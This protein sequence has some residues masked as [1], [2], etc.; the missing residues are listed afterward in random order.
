MPELVTDPS[1]IDARWLTDALREAGVLPRGRVREVRWR[2]IGTGK[3]GDNVRYDLLYDGA[4]ESAP[5]SVVAKLPAADATARASAGAQGLYRREVC[6]YREIAS[7]APIR[8]PAVHLTAM[9]ANGVDFVILMEDLAPAEP[10]DQIAGCRPER[11][12]LV[13]REAAKLH[14]PMA[15]DPILGAEWVMQATPEGVALVQAMLQEMW[16]GFA[17]RFE[18]AITPEGARLGER[19]TKSFP[20]W[21]LGF[22]G[23]ETLVHGDYRLENMLFGTESG[24]PPIAVVDW[25]SVQR[26]CPLVDVAYFLGAGLSIEDRRAHER[27]LVETYRRSLARL[28]VEI[29]PA[30]CWS[31]Y[32]RS[33]LHG[34]L[35]TVLGC[36]LSGRDERGDRMF[37]VMIERHLQHSI[38]L[39]CEEFLV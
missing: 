4:P 14:G 11:A 15:G 31:L 29:T 32:R 1:A 37:A 39:G 6:F 27:E 25:Q 36:M 16:P 35:I 19:F 12:D 24:G 9:D 7:R 13:L 34:I 8:T 20:E 5:S 30:D 2:T 21:T 22:F 23:P 28:G 10:G 17:G 38:D 26:S 3:I 18:R 33:A